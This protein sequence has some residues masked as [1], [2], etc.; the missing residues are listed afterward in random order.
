MVH[1]IFGWIGGYLKV[2][3]KGNNV[4]RFVNLCR[5]R[6]IMLWQIYLEPQKNVLYFRITLQD[7]YKLRPLA[8][9]CKVHPIVVKRY[10]LPF[11][12]GHMKKRASFCVGVLLCFS[13]VIFLST[14]IWGIF[15]EGQS[16]HTKESI[17]EYLDS[18]DVYGG[19][20]GEALECSQLEE[21]IRQKYNDIGWVSVE[22]KG[23]KIFV[24]LKEVL[25]VDKE[26][27]VKKGHLIAGEN[28]TVVSIVTRK[29]TAKVRA[30][31]TVKK[32]DVL[33]SGVV[34]IYGDN[35]ELVDKNYVH[36]EGTVVLEMTESYQDML[37]KE[38]EKGVYTGRERSVHEWRFGETKFFCYNPLKNLET[39]QKYDIIRDGGIVCPF[40]STRFPV[41][42]YVKT[43]REI[44]YQKTEYSKAD[45]EM[46]LQER[47]A[48]YLSQM[49][50]AGYQ[51][52][53]HSVSLKAENGMY[54]YTGDVVF[55]KEQTDYRSI[56]KK[57]AAK[58]S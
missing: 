44:A 20:A 57:K 6:G 22:R 10:G 48:Y 55:R 34:K 24:R 53:E 37:Q 21:Q 26:E 30:K 18:I 51:L 58:S 50:A 29:G 36:A 31:D 32:G 25:L 39:Y 11:L 33:I 3:I 17:L 15:I 8:R 19:I 23:S 7:F 12:I 5:N 9:K 56:Q 52:K 45:A 28:G 43:F 54:Y 13:L 40:L 47:F 42:H 49:E 2:R 35:Q 41:S 14:R 16:Y 38:Y 1:R 46:I 4:E 27:K